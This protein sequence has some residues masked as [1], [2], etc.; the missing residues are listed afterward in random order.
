MSVFPNPAENELTIEVSFVKNR[1]IE[2]RLYNLYGQ[3]IKKIY[4]G[5]VP[6]A[7]LHLSSDISELSGGLY[8][9]K[10]SSGGSVVKRFIK[11]QYVNS[12]S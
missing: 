3:L 4:E 8:F 11:L 1:N 12:F 9:I 10:L 2:I 6:P 5:K 7:T